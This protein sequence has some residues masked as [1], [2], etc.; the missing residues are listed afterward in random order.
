MAKRSTRKTTKKTATKNESENLSENLIFGAL[1]MSDLKRGLVIVVVVVL[2]FYALKYFKSQG[3]PVSTNSNDNINIGLDVETSGDLS[4]VGTSSKMAAQMAVDQVNKAGGLQVNGKNYQVVLDIQDNMGNLDVTTQVT[5]KLISN[6]VLAIVGPNASKYA[7]AAGEVAEQGKTLLISPWSTNPKTTLNA[8][9]T[10][11]KYVRRAAFVDPFQ[12]EA[13]A[14]FAFNNLK[15]TNAAVIYDETADVLKGQSDYFQ[16]KF[17]GAGGQIVDVQKF[18]SGD[19]DFSTQLN[20]ILNT[21]PQVIFLPA[22][23]KDAA[24]IINQAKS[25]GINAVFLGSDA[26]GSQEILTACGASCDGTYL[27]AHYS[28]DSKDPTTKKFVE[29][30]QALYG[31]APDDVA[32][33]TYDSFGMLF[34]A[35]QASPMVDRQAVVDAINKIT[36]YNGVTGVINYQPGNGDPTKTV[37]ILKISDGKFSYETSVEPK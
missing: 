25:M 35:I 4:A 10:H 5:Q 1:T 3:G 2:L 15:T 16:N 22:Y 17:K 14:L 12:G 28:A 24:A 36:K 8:D 29:A 7:I 30:Y 20:S 32:A 31:K 18:K 6:K 37:V 21:N 27:S 26:W 33:L 13:L 9:G 19:S 34:Q 11:K 23:F